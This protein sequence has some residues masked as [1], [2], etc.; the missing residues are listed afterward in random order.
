[1]LV[2][3]FL[4]VILFGLIEFGNAWRIYQIVTNVAREGARVGVVG[5]SDE[6]LVRQTIEDRL[7][8]SGLDPAASTVTLNLCSGASC[9]GEPDEVDVAYPF[10]FKFFAPLVRMMCLGSTSCG[11]H[12]AAVS[13]RGTA[14]MRNE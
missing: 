11:E 14:V 5:T 1:M 10:E 9:T 8:D 7:R 13:L 2:L 4:V 3:P 12:P 6:A